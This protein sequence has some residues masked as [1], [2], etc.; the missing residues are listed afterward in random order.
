MSDLIRPAALVSGVLLIGL[1]ATM[2]PCLIIEA[3]GRGRDSGAF[4]FA[5]LVTGFFGGVFTLA[6]KGRIERLNLRA[7]FVLTVA[8]WLV[9]PA[10]AALPFVLR[11]DALSVTDAVF[12]A[13]SGLTTTGATVMRD[14]DSQPRGILLW[15]A[16]LQWIGGVGILVTAIAILPMLSI[17]GM[18]LFRLESSD[19]SEKLMP[20]ATQIAG[21]IGFIYLALTVLCALVYAICGMSAFDSI[22]HAMT[23][24]A[25]GGFSTS[26]YSMGKFTDTGADIAAVFFMLLASLPFGAY[27]LALRGQPKRAGADPQARALLAVVTIVIVVMTIYLTTR[28]YLEAFEAL[29]A[30]AFSVVSIITGTG[31]ATHDYWGWGPFATA[32]FF[33]LTFVGGC[34]GSTSC[35]AKIFRFQIA[36]RALIAYCRQM[37]RPHAVTSLRYGGRTV[38]TEAVQSVLNF[39]FVYFAGYAVLAVILGGLGL[40]TV[41]AFSGAATAIANVGPGLGATIGP[42]GDFAPL[43]V[44]A[45]WA[46]TI[47]MLVGRL[48]FFTVLVLFAPHFWRG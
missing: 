39:F 44:G 13:M 24:I 15:R 26:S 5:M 35:G 30:A 41:T 1:A 19:R 34:A 17:G 9:L 37:I 42:M 22:A 47:G 3:A 27:M 48:E 33:I 16:I 32:V 43:P 11:P 4:G 10:F 2:A 12:E 23:T 31:Y 14:L 46:L 8:T 29:R 25:T 20:R 6:A 7:A 40:D 21:F 28:G 45:K 18:Q 36:F 38:P